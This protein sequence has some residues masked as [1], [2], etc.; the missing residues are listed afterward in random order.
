MQMTGKSK[1]AVF[2]FSKKEAKEEHRLKML[3]AKEEPKQQLM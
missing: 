2:R 3:Q 1:R